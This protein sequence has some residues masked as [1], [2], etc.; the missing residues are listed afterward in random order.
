MPL[1]YLVGLPLLLCGFVV[2]VSIKYR[3]GVVDD[4][5]GTQLPLPYCESRKT[6]LFRLVPPLFRRY[7]G[8]LTR[9]LALSLL[10]S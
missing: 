6:T 10:A 9:L 1:V 8:S 4:G 2:Q 5:Y 7:F 3:V